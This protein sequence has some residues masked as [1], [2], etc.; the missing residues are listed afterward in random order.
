M[1]RS[2]EQIQ[3]VGLLKMRDT[4]FFACI[5]S[6]GYNHQP[7]HIEKTVCLSFLANRWF[8]SVQP[9]GTLIGDSF[10]Q[11]SLAILNRFVLRNKLFRNILK[12]LVL[13]DNLRF[14]FC[15]FCLLL[16][17]A[18]LFCLFRWIDLVLFSFWFASLF[19][20]IYFVS[21]VSSVLFCFVLFGL[22]CLFVLLHFFFIKIVFNEKIKHEESEKH[23]HEI[24]YTLFKAIGHNNS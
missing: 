7:K 18:I 11:L 15:L 2:V 23:R 13:I 14:L 4:Q 5:K 20:Q 16:I 17:F 3:T 12:I 24:I 10:S 19:G 9:I 6:I 8:V 21:F 1:F 22:F